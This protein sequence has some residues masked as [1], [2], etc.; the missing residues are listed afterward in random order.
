MDY[1]RTY[2]IHVTCPQTQQLSEKLINWAE[3]V[4]ILVYM[5]Y[6]KELMN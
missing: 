5:D 6:L 4:H 1:L 3:L 2:G